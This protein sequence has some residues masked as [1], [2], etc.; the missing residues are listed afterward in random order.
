MGVNIVENIYGL[1]FI[2]RSSKDEQY[3]FF[4]VEVEFVYARAPEA[5]C[6]YEERQNGN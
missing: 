3:R 5:M 2:G 1:D 4:S 6:V